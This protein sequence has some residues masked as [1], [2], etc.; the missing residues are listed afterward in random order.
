MTRP[1]RRQGCQ[2]PAYRCRAS[3]MTAQLSRA[4]WTAHCASVGRTAHCDSVGRTL[5][6][7]G[8]STRPQTGSPLAPGPDRSVN[9]RMKTGRLPICRPQRHAMPSAPLRMLLPGRPAALSQP[10]ARDHRR[11]S[12]CCP[13]R[14]RRRP[15]RLVASHTRARE[16]RAIRPDRMRARTR[17]A[18]SVSQRRPAG[19]P[20]RLRHR[21]A[22]TGLA[23][24]GQRVFLRMRSS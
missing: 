17:G 8:L 18:E 12:G 7:I 23:R 4:L 21:G 2:A 5:G 13:T 22:R 20:R 19:K 6:L 15:R 16:A 10:L 1:S 24:P 9:L 11:S 3:R 14:A